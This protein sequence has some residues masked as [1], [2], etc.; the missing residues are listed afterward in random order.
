MYYLA[1]QQL[2]KQDH[3]DFGLRGMI[4]FLRYAG[5]KRLAHPKFPDDE[6]WNTRNYGIYA[7]YYKFLKCNVYKTYYSKSVVK[8]NIKLLMKTYTP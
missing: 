8:G 1:A 5:R 3:Y 6:V 2:S 7:V 4:S